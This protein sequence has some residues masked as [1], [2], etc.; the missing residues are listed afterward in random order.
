VSQDTTGILRI[1]CPQD[2]TGILRI[3]RCPQ[4]TAVSPGYRR[5]PQ[6]TVSPGYRGILG[7]PYPEDTPACPGTRCPQDTAPCPGD[8][9]VSSGCP[10]CPTTPTCVFRRTCTSAVP[11]GCAHTHTPLHPAPRTGPVSVERCV[12]GMHAHKGPGA[13]PPRP[14]RPAPGK[15]R[16]TQRRTSSRRPV[17]S[18]PPPPPPP[19]AHWSVLVHLHYPLCPL[20]L[21]TFLL[22]KCSTCSTVGPTVVLVRLAVLGQP[23]QPLPPES[24]CHT[25]SGLRHSPCS[26]GRQR[27]GRRSFCAPL[28]GG[29]Y[30]SSPTPP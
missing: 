11:V 15:T 27:L 13:V 6:D 5:Y 1:R 28:F 9:P 21:Y 29:G 14:A 16:S 17:T 3:P 26:R 30:E 22:T 25:D 20:A 23:A 4:D 12:C 10:P 24:F 19:R 7:T 2:T 18:S 8:I